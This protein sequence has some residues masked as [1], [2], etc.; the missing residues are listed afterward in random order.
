QFDNLGNFLIGGTGGNI[1]RVDLAGNASVIA[2]NT[3][4]AGSVSGLAYVA[5]GCSV[6]PFG[7]A[8]NGPGG[9]T[10]MVATGDCSIGGTITTT[11]IHHAANALGLAVLGLTEITPPLDLGLVFG[12]TGCLLY[13]N[14][15]LLAPALTD[16]SGNFASSITS[17]ATFAGQSL[18]VQHAVLEG[19]LFSSFT[20]SNAV[21]INY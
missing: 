5:G 12:A 15:D 16:G 11:S 14:P 7:T 18:F 10:T 8:C 4:P 17:N 13:T 3:S 2:T 20:S 21:R 1:W 9:P 19:A 6:N